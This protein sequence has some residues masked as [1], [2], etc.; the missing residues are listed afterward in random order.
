ME[1]ALFPEK[2]S[3]ELAGKPND[4]ST[5]EKPDDE[6]AVIASTDRAAGDRRPKRRQDQ[7]RDRGG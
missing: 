7:A 6:R 2:S 5:G 1:P 3:D 4:P